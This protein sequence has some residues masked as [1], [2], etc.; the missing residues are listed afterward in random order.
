MLRCCS[1]LLWGRDGVSSLLK[2]LPA[3]FSKILQK[4]R[5]QCLLAVQFA[6]DTLLSA[7]CM[8]LVSVY[9]VL[10]GALCGRSVNGCVAAGPQHCTPTHEGEPRPLPLAV[11]RIS[12]RG[13]L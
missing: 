7:T 2:F 9:I 13:E 6:V 3:P 10:V 1:S 11:L 4:T 12:A 5:L 8:C